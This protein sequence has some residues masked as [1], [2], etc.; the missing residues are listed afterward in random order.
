MRNGQ[1]VRIRPTSRFAGQFQ[2]GPDAEG[3]VLCQ[4]EVL[5]RGPTAPKKIDVRFPEGRTFWGVPAEA[6]EEIGE[7]RV[8]ERQ[9]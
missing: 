9:G 6:F 3:I 2:L 5:S 7:E 1:H 8:L 4:Y